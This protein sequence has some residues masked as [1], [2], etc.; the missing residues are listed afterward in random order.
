[1]TLE[2][3]TEGSEGVSPADIWGREGI[4]GSRNSNCKVPQTGTSRLGVGAAECL[5]GEIRGM[6]GG[7]ILQRLGGQGQD[8]GFYS[9]SDAKPVESFEQRSR[10]NL[11]SIVRVMDNLF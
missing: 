8:F 9:G 11:I 6:A 10:C 2:G 3:G 5:E 7:Q 4:P 1:M